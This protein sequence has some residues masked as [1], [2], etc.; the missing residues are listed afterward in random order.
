[1]VPDDLRHSPAVVGARRARRRG[2]GRRGGGRPGRGRRRGGSHGWGGG[3]P[4][5]G[6]APAAGEAATRGRGRLPA[7]CGGF[8][9]LRRRE[10][11]VK[12]AASRGLARGCGRRTTR[13]EEEVVREEKVEGVRATGFLNAGRLAIDCG[14]LRGW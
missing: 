2:A 10:A 5:R 7:T 12:G 1:M 14:L 13:E 3:D 9:W 4:R 6:R 8:P 11:A